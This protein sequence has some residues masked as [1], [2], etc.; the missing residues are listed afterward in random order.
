MKRTIKTIALCAVLGFSA[1]GCQKEEH[2][3]NINVV[4]ADE[5]SRTVFYSIDGQRSHRT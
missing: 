2:M 3:K 4:A 1:V 5:T